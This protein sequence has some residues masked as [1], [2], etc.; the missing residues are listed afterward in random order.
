MP[1]GV[2][3]S[4]NPPVVTLHGYSTFTPDF[5]KTLVHFA[6]TPDT[7]FRKLYGL[8]LLITPTPKWSNLSRVTG[9]LATALISRL[10]L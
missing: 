2:Q 9:S 8:E 6:I 4:L 3:L 1:F 7:K 5:L 10:S